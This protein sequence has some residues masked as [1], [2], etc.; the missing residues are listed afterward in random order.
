MSNSKII[1]DKQERLKW[2]SRAQFDSKSHAIDYAAALK[3]KYNPDKCHVAFW[4]ISDFPEDDYAPMVVIIFKN[5]ADEAAFLL[6][7]SL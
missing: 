2:Y 6:G 7:E 5:E 1:F 4:L 3:N